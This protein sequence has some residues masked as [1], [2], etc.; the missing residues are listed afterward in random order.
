MCSTNKV[1]IVSIQEFADNISPE[2]KADTTV[3]LAPTM[4]I[5]VGVRPEEVAE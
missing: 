3:V 5:L 2:R 4:N 1:K